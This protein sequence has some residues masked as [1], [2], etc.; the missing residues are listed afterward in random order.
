MQ[1]SVSP[2]FTLNTLTL[3][4]TEHTDNGQ[5][6][7]DFND[8]DIPIKI[9]HDRMQGWFFE[10]ACELLEKGHIVAAVHLVTPLIEA[11]HEHYQGESS[12]GKSRK[13]FQARAHILFP[14]LNQDA[15]DL[16]YKGL[17]SGFAHHGF[18]KD[19][20]GHYNILFT[21]GLEQAIEYKDKVLW[22]D[23]YKYIDV[24]SKAF[25]N[26]RTNVEKDPI[27]KQKFLSIWSPDWQMSLR[28]PGGSGTAQSV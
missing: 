7:Y 17:R 13:F 12:R 11:L 24:I 28:V 23:V 8:Q 1:I 3:I 14:N 19:D 22:V 21:G 20:D 16:L 25:D 10:P 6:H 27:C 15:Y 5:V 18:V 26:Y 2:R 4:V 9:Y